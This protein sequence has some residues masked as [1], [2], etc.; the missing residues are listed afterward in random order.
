MTEIVRTV[1]DPG[2]PSF[3]R[4]SETHPLQLPHTVRRQKDPCSDFTER[5]CLFMD[6]NT[7]PMGDQRIRG[8]ETADSASNDHDSELR[9]RHRPTQK[10]LR[11]LARSSYPPLLQTPSGSADSL[12][13]TE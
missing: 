3:H 10:M 13:W 9:L 6:R 12:G 7:K 11:K 5:G 2:A 4:R 8:E 1:A